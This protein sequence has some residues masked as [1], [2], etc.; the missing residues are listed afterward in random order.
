MKILSLKNITHTPLGK[1]KP[2]LKNVSFDIEQGSYTAI[3]GHNGSGKTLLA[4][5]MASFQKA[6]SGTI[7]VAPNTK[8][9]LVF[10]FP[11]NQRVCNVVSKD[12]ALGLQKLKE[13]EIELRTIE[14]LMLTGLLHEADSLC[15]KLSSGQTQ[16]QAISSSIALHPN[17]LILDD[18]ISMLDPTSRMDIFRFLAYWVHKG[19]TVIHIT[20]DEQA[21]RQAQNVIMLE[22]GKI[23]FAG[24]LKS[25]IAEKTFSEKILKIKI[26]KNKRN[27]K[28]DGNIV[29]L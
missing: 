29:L 1:K 28:I 6:E 10:Q 3:V 12:V 13:D 18:G 14:S 20:H 15:V 9:S 8:V 21:I 4:R 25:F 2:A 17:L 5:I 19:N 22:K 24:T 27:K 26:P 7:T 23:V 16:K 11:K